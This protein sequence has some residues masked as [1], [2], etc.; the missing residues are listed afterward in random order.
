MISVALKLSFR[1]F[2]FGFSR[3]T[4]S[5]NRDTRGLEFSR[6][7]WEKQSRELNKQA[8]ADKMKSFVFVN[9]EKLVGLLENWD[10]SSIVHY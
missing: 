10:D 5:A 6:M 7:A 2:N 1:L 4:V 9:G 3:Q 8:R